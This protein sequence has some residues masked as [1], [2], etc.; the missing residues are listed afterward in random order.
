MGKIQ[1]AEAMVEIL[2]DEGVEVIFGIPGA[3]ILPFYSALRKSGK[4]RYYLARHQQSTDKC[5]PET[6]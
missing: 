4:I 1:A 3:E 2:K 5:R 6:R